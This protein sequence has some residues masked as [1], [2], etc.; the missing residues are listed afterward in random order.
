MQIKCHNHNAMILPKNARSK[1]MP[2]AVAKIA[3]GS[4]LDLKTPSQ[5]S[6]NH[7]KWVFVFMHIMTFGKFFLL[8]ESILCIQQNPYQFKLS[9]F[10]PIPR[11]RKK[12]GGGFIFPR[13]AKIKKSPGVAFSALQG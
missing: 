11:V 2:S 8:P 1:T 12:F 5:T 3:G 6:P 10:M 7:H 4:I 13:G 9:A